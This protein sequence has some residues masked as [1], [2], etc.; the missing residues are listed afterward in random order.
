MYVRDLMAGGS[1]TGVDIS[2][3]R[4]E[5]TRSLIKKYGHEASVRLFCEDATTFNQGPSEGELLYDRV[6]VD[7]ECTH[8]GSLKHLKKFLKQIKVPAAE[9]DKPSRKARKQFEKNNSNPYTSEINSKNQWTQQDF[10]E[11]FLDP[12]KLEMLHGLQ[13][14]LIENGYRLLKPGGRLVYS[15]CSFDRGQNEGIVEALLQRHPDCTLVEPFLPEDRVQWEK[16]DLKYTV[17]FT[18]KTSNTGGL[19]LAAILKN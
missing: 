5:V 7:S 12:K 6:L 11:R 13:T 4:M 18:P 1:I 15:T 9:T 10:E 8:E 14:A 17:R 2:L 3:P 16:G 19:F